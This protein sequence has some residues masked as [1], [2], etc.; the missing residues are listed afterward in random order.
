MSVYIKTHSY[1]A[2]PTG[3]CCV[4][5][6]DPP[7]CLSPRTWAEPMCA[8]DSLEI[9]AKSRVPCSDV[10]SVAWAVDSVV[11]NGGPPR[12]LYGHRAS[13]RGGLT[14]F[15]RLEEFLLFFVGGYQFVAV[16]KVHSSRHRRKS[17]K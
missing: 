10:D 9:E 4:P 13:H 17:H 6:P 3:G 15:R 16:Y 14:D 5:A 8:L 12:C 2:H 11:E 1:P 7:F